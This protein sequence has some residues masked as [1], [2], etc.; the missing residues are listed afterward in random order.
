MLA[1]AAKLKERSALAESLSEVQSNNKL[2]YF[3]PESA[4]ENKTKLGVEFKVLTSLGGKRIAYITSYLCCDSD[5]RTFLDHQTRLRIP[6]Q[7][8]LKLTQPS[9]I[10][11]P[12]WIYITI[13]LKIALLCYGSL[14]VQLGL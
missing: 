14:C 4:K 13:H 10:C 3:I 8:R 2:K 9:R 1:D 12:L 6:L 5:V 7:C 11:L